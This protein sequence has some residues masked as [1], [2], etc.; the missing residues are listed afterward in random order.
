MNSTPLLTK[1]W[2][3]IQ[4]MVILNFII[5]LA[6][7]TM[8][9]LYSVRLVRTGIERAHGASFQ[10]LLRRQ[11]GLGG[12]AMSGL[13]LAVIMQSSAAVALLAAGFAASGL[14]SFSMALAIVLGGDLGSALIV[15]ILSFPV[16]WIVAPLLAIGGWLVVKSENQRL[17]QYGRIVMG[18]ALILVSLDL[19]REVVEPVRDS[20]F[21]PSVASY[22]QSDLVTGFLVGAALAFVMHSGVAAILVI[23]TLVQIDALSF[24]AGLAILF[25]ANLGSGLIPVWLTRD[26]ELAAKRVVFANL[27]LRGALAFVFLVIAIVIPLEAVEIS[28]SVGPAQL[29]IFAHI[30]FNSVL[31][32][33]A[34]PF[35]RLLEPL[36][37]RLLPDSAIS[38]QQNATLQIVS[39]L[40]SD[41][42]SN[43]ALAITAL[44]RELLTMSGVVEAMFRP[45]LDMYLSDDAA[46][47]KNIQD[48]D[49]RVNT[50]LADIRRFGASIPKADYQ[51]SEKKSARDLVEY[52]IRLESAGDVIAKR[53]T[54]LA[55]HMHAKKLEFSAEGRAELICLHETVA[56]NFKLAANV[57]LSDD[58]ESARLLS[59]EKT[60]LKRA[61]RASRKKHLKRLQNG[62]INSFETSDIHLETLRALREVS[63]HISAV[64]YPLLY[65]TGQLLET[66]LIQEMPQKTVPSKD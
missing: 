37:T 41:T 24:A 48:R 15:Q 19:L 45:A 54:T 1:K 59:L 14:L 27:A 4:T 66:R 44:K 57:L 6:G 17:R 16:G 61:E 22:L 31:L 2:R 30:G 32:T 47:R 43:P 26:M 18:I 55:G 23:V 8:L 20:A 64:A 63:S 7:A 49:N 25:G 34:L 65:E 13:A 50:F 29:L 35:C 21:L 10:R 62:N 33:A 42:L 36:V 12:T 38:H 51:K 60:E 58:P 56:A 5:G 52:A 40:E 9:L 11:K 53:M 3:E 46:L 39:N 28:E